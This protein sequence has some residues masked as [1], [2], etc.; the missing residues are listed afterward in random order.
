[1]MQDNIIPRIFFAFFL[2]LIVWSKD[3]FIIGTILTIISVVITTLI[4]YN[5]P[6]HKLFLENIIF[7]K[8]IYLAITLWFILIIYLIY[9][10]N[11]LKL[12]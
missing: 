11:F 5:N 9:K 6:I 4:P 8:L 10:S 1:M 2:S 12:F 7:K 3:E